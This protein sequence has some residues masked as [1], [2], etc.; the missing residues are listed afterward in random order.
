MGLAQPVHHNAQYVALPDDAFVKALQYRPYVLDEDIYTYALVK[1]AH[2]FTR[3]LKTE[4]EQWDYLN[5][6]FMEWLLGYQG[7]TAYPLEKMWSL[8]FSGPDLVEAFSRSLSAAYPFLI[9]V[10]DQYP[11]A[12]GFSLVEYGATGL[13]LKVYYDHA[14]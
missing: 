6:R 4:L 1:L 9:P 11:D 14:S 12:A 10:I 3:V 8:G 7:H 13:L 5:G 2:Y